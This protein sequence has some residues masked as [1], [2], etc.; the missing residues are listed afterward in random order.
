LPADPSGIVRGQ[1]GRDVVG[2]KEGIDRGHA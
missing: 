2:R 1:E